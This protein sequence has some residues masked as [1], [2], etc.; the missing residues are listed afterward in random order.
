MTNRTLAM[1]IVSARV[2]WSLNRRCGDWNERKAHRTLEEVSGTDLGQ[3]ALR[4]HRDA[5]SRDIHL[6]EQYIT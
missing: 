2:S 1:G 6:L 4:Q 5:L 3:Q